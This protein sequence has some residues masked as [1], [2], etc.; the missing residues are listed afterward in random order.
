MQ[1][2]AIPITLNL[3][4]QQTFR[5]GHMRATATTLASGGSIPAGEIPAV[6]KA[7]ELLFNP[8]QVTG[9]VCACVRGIPV[10][11]FGPGVAANGSIGCG[12]QGL[13]NIDYRMVQDHDTTPGDRAT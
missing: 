9:L 7:D 5:T 8:V 6:I 12:D 2:Q 10:A 3:T 13:S 1:T 4:G 11:A